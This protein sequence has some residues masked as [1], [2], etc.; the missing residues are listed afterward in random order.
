VEFVFVPYDFEALRAAAAHAGLTE[1]D[2]P[3]L[4]K[5]PTGAISSVRETID[6]AAESPPTAADHPTSGRAT[7][8][9]SAQTLDD[10]LHLLRSQTASASRWKKVT[11]VTAVAAALAI[12][13][14]IGGTAAHL[15]TRVRPIAYP[16]HRAAYSPADEIPGGKSGF[17]ETLLPALYFS[18]HNGVLSAAPFR[19][20]L[21]DRRRQTFITHR[22]DNRWVTVNAQPR[23]LTDSPCTRLRIDLSWSPEATLYYPC[24][25]SGGYGGAL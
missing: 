12:L 22:V 1:E 6:F 23:R 10:A 5:S 11:L 7:G 15:G 14:L 4:S 20:T 3:L 16:P 19:I 2:Y 18:T 13:I 25:V 8:D 21:T 17:H 24:S 9:T